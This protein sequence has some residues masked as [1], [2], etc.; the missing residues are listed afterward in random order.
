LEKKLEGLEEPDITNGYAPEFRLI[1][2]SMPSESFPVTILQNSVKLTIEPPLGVK[3]SL[4]KTYFDLNEQRM[5]IDDRKM[6]SYYRLTFAISLFHAVVLERRKFGYIGF[7]ST[8]HFN[9]SDLETSLNSLKTIV[10]SFDY[11]AWD[12]M[13]YLTG[14]INYGGRITDEW[15]RRCI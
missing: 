12:A 15:D 14:Q 10:E 2:T 8:Y 11:L 13:N 3:N 5:E 6:N 9:D 1:L 4:T 7:N